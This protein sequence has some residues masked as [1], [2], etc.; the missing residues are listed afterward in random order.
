[1][2]FNED[3]VFYIK[4]GD[5]EPP[6][7]IE[8]GGVSGNL[9]QVTDWIVVGSREGVEVFSDSA[10]AFTPGATTNVG[11]VKHIWVAGQTDVQGDMDIEV[12][13]IWPGDRPQTFPPRTY[14]RVLVSKKLP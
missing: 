4:Q 1:M 5:L 11:T 14:C 7:E 3:E 2:N 10:A 13:A 8:V 12:R 9:T 6:L